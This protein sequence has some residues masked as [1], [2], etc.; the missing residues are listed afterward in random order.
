MEIS[1]DKTT[2]IKNKKE[3]ISS[4]VL[5]N[6]N[7][8]EELK[9]FTFLVATISEEGSKI[10]VLCRIPLAI[11]NLIKIFKYLERKIFQSSPKSG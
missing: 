6:G 10:D 4:E 2:I 8:L 9:T 7:K 5:V 3:V 1:A 11:A